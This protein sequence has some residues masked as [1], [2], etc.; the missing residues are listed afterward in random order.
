[1]TTTIT[2]PKG[3]PARTSKAFRTLG[4]ATLGLVM[5]LGMLIGTVPTASAASYYASAIAPGNNVRACADTVEPC[6]VL[7]TTTSTGRMQCWRDAGWATGRYSSNRWFLMELSNGQEGFVHSSFVTNQ[8]SVPNCNSLARVLAADFALAQ[9]KSRSAY[10][11]AEYGQGALG[12][13]D[14]NPGPNRE[15]S[16]DCA[17]LPY[18][19]Y[20]RVGV[21]YP[22]NH[23]I[24]QWTDLA[25]RRGNNAYLPRYG[26]PVFFAI[27]TYG[28]TGLYIG[29]QSMVGTQSGDW[30]YKPVDIY[31]LFNNGYGT[32]L[33]W[34]KVS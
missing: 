29:G 27:G 22:L 30:A 11:P 25:S 8:T 4:T 9:V 3:R 21:S 6:R 20:K 12:G 33:G 13:M 7:T 16:G 10:A 34:A 19:A 17:K 24:G 23:A 5:L 1:M 14:W 26:D 31:P 15:W 2:G 32:Y 28:H 18:I